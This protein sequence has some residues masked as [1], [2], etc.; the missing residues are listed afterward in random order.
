MPLV[1]VAPAF[2]VLADR[3]DKGVRQ[4]GQ[5]ERIEDNHRD[6]RDRSGADRV[7]KGPAIQHAKGLVSERQNRRPE[8]HGQH[9]HAHA[10]PTL[11]LIHI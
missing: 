2:G 9:E 1:N 7:H 6:E 4:I 8:R 5:V 10:R 11:S 3:D